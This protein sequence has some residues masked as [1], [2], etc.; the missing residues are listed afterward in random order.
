MKVSPLLVVAGA[1]GAI[2]AWRAL[3]SNDD[4]HGSA[5]PPLGGATE[6]TNFGPPPMPG[7]PTGTREFQTESDSGREWVR[8]LPDQ[9]SDA[10]EDAIIAAVRAGFF[11]SPSWQPIEFTRDQIRVRFFAATDALM[12]GATDPIRINARHGTAQLIADLLGC[13]LPTSRMS[14]LA[15][16]AAHDLGGDI[17]PQ[18]LPADRRMTSIARMI[19][20]SDLVTRA[21]R[22][23]GVPEGEMARDVGKDWVNTE[24]LL[25]A[26]GSVASSTAEGSQPAA[27]NFGWH[28][29]ASSSKSPGKLPVIQSVG[30]AHGFTHVDYSQVVTLYRV[31]CE[32]D[33]RSRAVEEVLRDPRI[34]YLLSDE[35]PKGL[36]CRVTRYPL[37]PRPIA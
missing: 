21:R 3:T 8:T 9:N 35:V 7:V 10:R 34:A 14:D 6:P 29:S 28:I 20:H 5:A 23:R 31:D 12:I 19:E 32:I 24:R 13:V 16:V 22:A 30:L 25:E 26:D 11:I 1:V 27:A 17:P 37:V 18:I 4:E 15:W 36:D 2:A 33:G